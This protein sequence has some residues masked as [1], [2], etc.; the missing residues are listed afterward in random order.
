M[1]TQI[2]SAEKADNTIETIFPVGGMTCAAC[3]NSVESM[4][5]SQEGVEKVQVN[6]A[7]QTASVKYHPGQVSPDA[8]QK[9]VKSIGYDLLIQPSEADAEALEKKR[10]KEYQTLKFRTIGALLLALPVAVL[11][12]AYHH[13]APWMKWTEMLLSAPVVFGF[14][15]PFFKRAFAQARHGRANMD[16][17]V[18]V[19]T[20]IAFIFSA[21]N[22]IYPQY[23]ESRG[24]EAQVYYEAAAVIVGFILLG[25]LLEERAKTRTS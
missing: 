13:P 18:A 9:V 1:E 11:G 21:F 24:L 15:W 22:T 8:M 16:T 7:S 12:M 17:L 20:G 19:S 23:F 4:L 3:A 5:Q 6:Y 10:E 25:K 2:K 14:G